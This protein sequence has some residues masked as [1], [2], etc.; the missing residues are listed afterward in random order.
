M[1]I[2]F[3]CKDDNIDESGYSHIYNL[4]E[5]P[6]NYSNI[7]FP[8]TF[9]SFVLS[10]DSTPEDNQ[11]TDNGAT[12]GRVLFYDK[13]LSVN[14]TISC[15]S[16]HIQELGFSDPRQ[17]SIGFNGEETRRN[18]MNLVNTGF[19][20]P[21]KFFW[22]H[23]IESLEKQV[24]MPLQDEIEM[25]M[26][27]DLLVE[28]LKN[29]DYYKPLFKKAFGNEE[30]TA[31]K[32]S[33]ALVQFVRSIY[34]F[35]SKYDRGIE[36]TKDIF[37]DFPNFTAQENMGKDIFNGKLTPTV[38]GNCAFC[39]MTN[40]NTLHFSVPV[41]FD[42]ANQVIFSAFRADN[43]GLDENSNGVD[44][45]LG[46]ITNNNSDNGRFKT[47]SLRNIE[48]TAP[49]MHDGRFETLEEVVEHY[50][51]KVK[52]HPNL[53]VFL[54]NGDGTPRKLELSEEEKNALV[55]FLKTLTDYDM[56]ND[57]KYSDP[58]VE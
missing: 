52:A 46:E 34:S 40:V 45:G 51:T 20:E 57:I 11:I 1:S 55:A 56:I 26:T 27:I 49:Y 32:I 47:P 23:R 25:G 6:Y 7:S 9:N 22:D 35:N 54:R 16:C 13:R 36:I 24:L 12:L 33:K 29:T 58:F 8:E 14:N 50:S 43:I 28:K 2:S 5:I 39:H 38:N 10:L 41:D 15:A 42:T 4:P 21:N 37:K 30:I 3:S 44:N 18:S 19:Y 31:E 48:L 17:K 53:S